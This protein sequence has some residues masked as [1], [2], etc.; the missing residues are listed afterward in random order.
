[1]DLTEKGQL[2]S[3]GRHFPFRHSDEPHLPMKSTFQS[4]T[5]HSMHAVCFIAYPR[6]RVVADLIGSGFMPAP[7]QSGYE[8][9]SSLVEARRL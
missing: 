1:M 9:F 7:Q 6:G 8:A 2:M 5:T 4:C 3:D